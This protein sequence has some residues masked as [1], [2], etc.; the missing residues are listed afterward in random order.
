VVYK[1]KFNC[2]VCEEVCPAEPVAIRVFAG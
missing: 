1:E 2:L